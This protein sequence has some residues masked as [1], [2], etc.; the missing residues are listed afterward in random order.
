LALDK[1]HQNN[2]WDASTCLAQA[3]LIWSPIL[4]WLV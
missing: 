1:N 4:G 3:T 2:A